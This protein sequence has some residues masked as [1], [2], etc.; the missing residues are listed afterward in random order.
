MVSPAPYNMKIAITLDGIISS[1][2]YTPEMSE[3][4]FLNQVCTED[5]WYAI[6]RWFFSG[7]DLL[8]ISPRPKNDITERW[9]NEWAIIYSNLILDTPLDQHINVASANKCDMIVIGDKRSASFPSDSCVVFG[10]KSDHLQ[11]TPSK[12]INYIG[13]L[14]EL[15][16]VIEQWYLQKKR[17]AEIGRAH[18]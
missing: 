18:V 16:E 7:H 11:F 2:H 8:L 3:V 10:L 15:D 14:N 1:K 6:N 12:F 13:R 9:L 5:G 4:D 17:F